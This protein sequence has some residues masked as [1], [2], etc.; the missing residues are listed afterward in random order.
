MPEP[1][2]DKILEDGE[3]KFQI[4]E[5]DAKKITKYTVKEITKFRDENRVMKEASTVSEAYWQAFL[6]E[7]KK[8]DDPVLTTE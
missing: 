7:A 3:V 4:T 2:Y 5:I 8:I 1:T 6:D